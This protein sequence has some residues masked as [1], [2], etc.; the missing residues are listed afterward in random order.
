MHSLKTLNYSINS[1]KKHRQ[2]ESKKSIILLQNT[3]C[4]GNGVYSNKA[5]SHRILYVYVLTATKH[6]IKKAQKT[7]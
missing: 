1:S 6:N 3:L 5:T 4:P 2:Y 7:F